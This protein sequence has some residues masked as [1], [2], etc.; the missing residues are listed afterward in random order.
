MEKAYIGGQAVIEGVMMRYKDKYAVAVRTEDQKIESKTWDA[1]DPTSKN[2]FL[3]FPV[4]RGVVN[5]IESLVVGMKALMYSSSFFEEEEE[6]KSKAAKK[7]GEAVLTV[8]T[9]VLSLVIALGLFV[10]LPM[11]L[12]TLFRKVIDNNIIIALIEGVIRLAV[13]ILYVWAIS[14]M[15]DMRRVYMYHGAEHKTINCFEAGEALTPAIVMKYTRFHKRCGTSFLFT[16]VLISIFFF[17]FIN[18]EDPKLRLLFRILLVP[19]IAGVS[20]EVIRFAGR[21]DNAFVNI[22]SAP[23]K[24]VQKLTTREPDEDM[25]EVAIASVEAVIDWR[26]YQEEMKAGGLTEGKKAKPAKKDKA[27]KSK[28]KAKAE[29]T[30]APETDIPTPTEEPTYRAAKPAFLN[31]EATYEEP[32]YQDTDPDDDLSVLQ[33]DN[34]KDVEYNEEDLAEFFEDDQW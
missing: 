27:A 13:F 34:Y 2:K 7:G 15:K 29:P 19:V 26:A 16:V 24:L 18:V 17:A 20:Y 30:V 1:Q 5:F 11:F 6:K 12:S 32:E 8:L 33:G 14:L 10:V 21:H 9:M 25:I 31:S 3:G 23:G 4:I 22:L 28:Q